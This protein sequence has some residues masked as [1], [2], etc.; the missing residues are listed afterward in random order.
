MNITINTTDFT[1]DADGNPDRMTTIHYTATES[2]DGDVVASTYGTVG[3]DLEY[4]TTTEL[5][6]IAAVEAG[7]PDLQATL[8]AQIAAIGAPVVG[9]G[10]PWEEQFPVWRSGVAYAVGE[11]VN[12]QGTAYD[13][14]QAHTSQANW[15]PPAVP[16]LFTVI[17][18]PGVVDK[19]WV[20]G[21][22]VEVGDVR[23]Y[24]TVNDVS[25]TCLQAHTTQAGWEPPNV[26]AL[27]EVT[28]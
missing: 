27:W 13:V 8:D 10:K 12:Y 11:K 17:T 26:P 18:D 14:I 6:A 9:T 23:F 4:A 28:P 2:V 16:A 25:Y 20:A 15:T 5:D 22:A 21:E 1:V 7:V 19:P 3:V 24:P